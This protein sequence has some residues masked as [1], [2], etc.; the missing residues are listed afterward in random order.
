MLKD[1]DFSW[2]L[3]GHSERRQYCGETDADVAAKVEVCQKAGVHVAVCI[4]EHLN[5]RKNG[6]MSQVLST[7][8][9]AFIGMFRGFGVVKQLENACYLRQNH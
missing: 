5:Q 2:T 7:Q 8:I 1:L 3:V 9:Q 4:G 6:E